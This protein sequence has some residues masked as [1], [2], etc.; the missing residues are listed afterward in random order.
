ME[1][2]ADVE[3]PATKIARLEHELHLAVERAAVA[4]AQLRRVSSAVRAFKEKQL[5]ARSA[6]LAAGLTTGDESTS[7]IYSAWAINDASL[8]ERL[9]NYLESDFEPDRSRDWM[10]E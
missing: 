6:R 1:V 4:E 8:D 9:T 5:S 10:L 7:G 3:S 2:Q